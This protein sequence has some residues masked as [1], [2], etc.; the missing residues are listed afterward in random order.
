MRE[1]TLTLTL[2]P[3]GRGNANPIH[4]PVSTAKKFRGYNCLV[5]VTTP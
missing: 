1:F 5:G 2:S 3:Q 4:G